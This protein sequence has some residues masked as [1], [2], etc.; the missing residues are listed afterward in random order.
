MAC[1][2]PQA[3]KSRLRKSV[4][5]TAMAMSLLMYTPLGY[6][7][8]NQDGQGQNGNDNSTA[9]P[10]KHVIII[11]GENRSFDHLYATSKSGR[12]SEQLAFRGHH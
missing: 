9:S 7:G 2:K 3:R 12:E 6:G 4:C 11:V 8:Q 10:I 1:S 5:A